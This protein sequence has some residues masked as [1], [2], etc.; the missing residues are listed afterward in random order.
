MESISLIGPGR[1]GTTLAK[2]LPQAGYPVDTVVGRTLERAKAAVHFAGTGRPSTDLGDV[3]DSSILLITTPDG[4]IE[5]MSR[6]LSHLDPPLAAGTIVAHCSGALPAGIPAPV[7][8]RDVLVGSAH[9]IQ[10]LS[11]PEEGV[12][13]MAGTVWGLEGDEEACQR[14]E[15][16]VRALQGR[17]IL[18]PAGPGKALY[19]ATAVVASNYLVALA[20]LTLSLGAVA[21]LDPELTL[22][23]LEPLVRG[24]L[25]NLKKCGSP[26]EA[27]TGPIVRGDVATVQ[28]HL[29]AI[30]Q[31][32]PD[33]LP[34][35]RSLGLRTVQVAA[36]RGDQPEGTLDRI[37]RLLGDES[38]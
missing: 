4:V 25:V 24:T 37:A 3:T 20:D 15:P 11:S 38:G 8:S 12:E 2:L 14:L 16:L 31:I 7:A 28:G 30:E 9:P 19:H 35:Y 1:L 18:V 29:A 6:A 10:S 17:P 5:P 27:L 21:G 36:R 13:Q 26:A 33:A 34:L 32:L 22:A 23:A